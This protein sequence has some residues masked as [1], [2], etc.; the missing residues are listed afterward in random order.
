MRNYFTYPIGAACLP[1]GFELNSFGEHNIQRVY[2]HRHE[3]YELYL[4]L[5]GH[6]EFLIGEQTV[7]L[8]PRTLLLLPPN[9]V[10]SLRFLDGESVYQRTV[11]WVSP[12]LFERSSPEV[13]DTPQEVMLSGPDGA[14]VEGLLTLLDAEQSRMERDFSDY[15]GRETVY[16]DYI[17]L[18]LTHLCRLRDRAIPAS[19]FLRRVQGYIEAHL[20]GDLSAGAIARALHV[21]KSHLMRR[22]REEAGVSLHQYILKLRLLRARRLLSRG[23]TAA[24]SA[25]A[26][27]FFDY[28]TFYKAF[29]REYGMTPS[30]FRDEF[31]IASSA[32]EQTDTES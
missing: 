4:F 9:T 5:A 26:A 22:F 12:A 13:W 7:A 3:F 31:R 8:K 32:Q 11:L 25:D 24:E 10:H 27:G 21:G 19:P 14:A 18:I 20:A 17:R 28:T 2:S 1:N 30:R 16:A 29:I 15:E 23:G 6:A